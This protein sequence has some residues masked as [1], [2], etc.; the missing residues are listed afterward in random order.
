MIGLASRRHGLPISRRTG[1]LARSLVVGCAVALSGPPSAVWAQAEMPGLPLGRDIQTDPNA[2]MLLEA[3]ELVYDFDRELVSAVGNVRVFYNGYE[4]ETTRITYHRASGRLIASGG[5]RIVEPGGNIITAQE[6]DITDD[7][8]D[9]FIQALQVETPERTRFAAQS[10]ERR[11]GEVTEFRRGVYTACEPCEDNPARPPLWQVKASTIIHNQVERTVTYRNAR[12]EF[13]GLPIAYFPWFQHPDPTVKRKTG[14][15]TPSFRYTERLG[16]GVTV[17]FFWAL[18]PHYDVTFRPTYYTRQGLLGRAE[19]RHRLMHGAYNIRLAGILQQDP[20]AFGATHPANREF[21][22]NAETSGQFEVSPQWSFGWDLFTTS[23]RTFGRDYRINTDLAVPATVYLTGMSDLN[24]FDARGYHFTIQRRNTTERDFKTVEALRLMRMHGNRVGD[25]RDAALAASPFATLGEARRALADAPETVP[26]AL[27]DFLELQTVTHDLQNQQAWVHP[28][29]DHSYIF[30]PAYF[31]GELR[32][33]SNITSLSRSDSDM[34]VLPPVDYF[35][36]VAGNF[37]RGATSI[38][39]R[40]RMI[41][42]GGQE[43]TPFAYVNADLYSVNSDDPLAPLGDNELLG[44]AMPALGLEYR[45]PFLAVSSWGAQTF[46]PVAQV[47]LR[48]DEQ[49]IGKLPNE[50]AQSLVFD[51]SILFEWDKFSG[52]DRQEG[53]SRANLGVTYLGQFGSNV[54]V[55]AVFGQSIHLF[56]TNSFAVGDVA[57]VGP[58]T[59]LETDRSDYVGRVTVNTGTILSFTARGRFDKDD[60]E[61]N[62][63]EIS[64]TARHGPATTTVGY[65][66]LGENPARGILDERE[67]VRATA[68][69]G[70]TENW[71]VAGQYVYD[72]HNAATVSQGI[73]LAYDDECFN[74]SLVYT[75]THNRYTDTP[76]NRSVTLR[77]N[78]R[79]IGGAAYTQRLGNE[80]DPFRVSGSR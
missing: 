26:P 9:G 50:D 58:D 39:W 13:F 31:G 76:A 48:L 56:G 10:A 65:V 11:S 14:F 67:E 46:G 47:I 22:G 28:V 77:F 75:E 69:L 38:S 4:V 66:M 37:T 63:S 45:W 5:V 49:H 21:R 72:V 27:R 70:V 55:D 7:F 6:A 12:L 43:F 41:G 74:L 15:L 80:F 40:R 44:R 52:W 62:R 35:S 30:A 59:G 57:R 42:P 34:R 17:P 25:A 32:I 79:T 64:A 51:D 16:Y 19:W 24:F 68:K 61:L 20:E 23:D 29:V 36:G 71:S 33:D 1:A 73:G 53:G 3:D 60:F 18:A 54:S 78:L 2:Q 8:A